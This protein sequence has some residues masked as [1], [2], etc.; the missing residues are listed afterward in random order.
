MPGL[1]TLLDMSETASQLP[2]FCSSMILQWVGDHWSEFQ[3]DPGT[4]DAGR[5]RRIVLDRL[6]ADYG[7]QKQ[8]LDQYY[9]KQ[10]LDISVSEVLVFQKQDQEASVISVTVLASGAGGTLL[11]Q[12]ERLSFV[13]QTIDP[14]TGLAQKGSDDVADVA[15]SEA[16]D[17]V[18]H[19][20]EP[21]AYLYPLRFRAVG[22]PDA[23]AWMKLKALA[24]RV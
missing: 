8:L 13:K 11:P 15:W 1:R 12:V 17:I 16:M 19:L 2:H 4:A 14:R 22:F 3:F 9:Q 20:F 23:D 18:G 5:Q 7:F 21:V 24:R 10:G 6:T